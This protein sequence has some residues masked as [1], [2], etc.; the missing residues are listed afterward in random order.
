MPTA[1]EAKA[2]IAAWI[3]FYNGRRPHM[4][5]ANRTP[6]AVWR[7]GVTGTTRR[8]GCGHDAALG[9]RWRVA[10]M[11]TAAT[12]AEDDSLGKFTRE[13]RHGFHLRNRPELVLVM[14]STSPA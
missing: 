4:A 10:H 11:P 14:G 2:G 8:N 12:T 7:E 1:R 3:A 9:Q 5:L 13:E 6:M